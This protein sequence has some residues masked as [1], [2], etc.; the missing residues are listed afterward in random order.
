M[1]HVIEID[2]LTKD[3][4]EGRGVFDVNLTV[5]PG[6]IFG[7]VGINGSGKTT[8]IR[9]LM[10][11]LRPQKGT[12]SIE[13]RNCWKHAAELKK[14]IG[15]VP[16]EI[17][18]PDVRTG[19]DFFNL[20]AR[21]LGIRDKT[22][23]NS[24]IDRFNLDA[25]APLKRMSKGMKQKTAIVAGFMADAPIL[26]LDEGTTGLDPLMQK[27]FTE[28][29]QEEKAQGRTMFMS[30]HMF[31]ELEATCDRVAFLK[32]GR[33]IDVVDMSLLGGNEPVKEYKVEFTSD[34][35]YQTFLAQS[36][37]VKRH[38]DDYK[39]VSVL[40]SDRDLNALFA[41]LSGLDVRYITQVPRTLEDQFKEKYQESEGTNHAY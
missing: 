15:H 17:S 12:C 38:R 11:Y 27:V 19:M 13:G 3:Y 39:Q 25:S 2:G 33:I 22:R 35:D 30:S 24:L 21:Y 6:E 32:E 14:H 1:N 31:D 40:L 18:F 23:V 9:H 8:T 26:L 34:E 20:Q 16:G 4:G 41:S 10:G 7:L 37:L 28:L 5:E 29:V 36:F